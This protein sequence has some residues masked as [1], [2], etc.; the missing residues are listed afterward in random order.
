M[1]D[2]MRQHVERSRALYINTQ[3]LL[4]MFAGHSPGQTE[5]DDKPETKGDGQ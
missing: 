3:N 4:G 1:Q 5:A 2:L